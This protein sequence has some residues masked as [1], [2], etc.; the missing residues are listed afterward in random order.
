MSESKPGEIP[1]ADD[2][3]REMLLASLRNCGVQPAPRMVV[4]RYSLAILAM[5]FTM[6]VAAILSAIMGQMLRGAPPAIGFVGNALLMLFSVAV[7]ARIRNRF[8][9]HAWQSSA[10]SAENELW[11][12]GAR[13]PIFYL[14][15][16]ALDEQLA[17]PTFLER[18]FGTRP[19]STI[20]QQ[21]TTL[22]RRLGPVIAIG[23]PGEKLP[24]LG[25][26]RFYVS[27][28]LWQ[29][30]VADVVK[31][32]QLVVWASGLS[33]GLG[34]EIAHLVKEIDPKQF[35]L[36]AHPH[37][38]RRSPAETEA[39][40]TKFLGKF[41]SIFPQPL[42]E[43]LGDARF[44]LFDSKWNPIPVA[45]RLS[46]S[47]WTRQTSA[48]KR[49]L[50]F[51]QDGLGEM[52]TEKLRE[53][54][55]DR[56]TGDFGSIIGA[57]STQPKWWQ[58]ATFFASLLVAAWVSHLVL[59]LISYFARDSYIIVTE[60]WSVFSWRSHL[61]I[62]LVQ[63]IAA[64]LAFRFI[65]H[66]GVAVLAAA[67][68]STLVHLV[69]GA[70][71]FLTFLEQLALF[72]SLAWMMRRST[73]LF[74]GAWWGIFLSSF[75]V[76]V[77]NGNLGLLHGYFSI[78]SIAR[79]VAEI[80]T[81]PGKFL[82]NPLASA[83]LFTLTMVLLL[84]VV[85][86]LTGEEEVQRKP[87]GSSELSPEL[88][89]LRLIVWDIGRVLVG[90]FVLVVI[91]VF[92]FSPENPY[93]MWYSKYF[94]WGEFAFIALLF[95]VGF[96]FLVGGVAALIRRR[97]AWWVSLVLLLVAGLAF[98]ASGPV[99]A[100]IYWGRREAKL[101]S[102]MNTNRGDFRWYESVPAPLKRDEAFPL[103]I[104]AIE[105][106]LVTQAAYDWNVGGPDKL[107]E[108]LA[109]RH[110]SPLVES[111]KKRAEELR[112]MHH[113]QQVNPKENTLQYYQLWLELLS[114]PGFKNKYRA[115]YLAEEIQNFHVTKPQIAA[116]KPKFE[117]LFAASPPGPS[118]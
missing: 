45:P 95:S 98:I 109:A 90:L 22:L 82:S 43:K 118:Q 29:S 63:T 54:A 34:W 32:S 80:A 47:V 60:T 93:R 3:W 53:Q 58:I 100:R 19:F 66:D 44:F 13:R 20:E 31:A 21:V 5:F 25:A 112:L 61:A 38:L 27:D 68:G 57:R 14:R 72:G 51:R 6:G 96:A 33:E 10:R 88:K 50:L 105:R 1:L 12:A 11:R 23:R 40:W 76:S 102:E 15:S 116:L 91:V 83:T 16:F 94:H 117:A 101:W 28:E 86:R 49:T 7:L 30:K 114:R 89:L 17:R 75:V 106:Q 77:V 52:T 74:A 39:E 70:G 35:V 65:R 104:E 9:R 59:W 37:L 4:L 48:L 46:D 103:W 85:M 110:D 107:L 99:G 55:F 79:D 81:T 41:G 62:P 84:K 69:L 108:E 64:V 36:W 67:A 56:D 78:Q 92:V 42:P 97:L 2:V 115:K 71:I 24:P 111:A 113:G 18:Y 87:L 26:A 73:R 8:L